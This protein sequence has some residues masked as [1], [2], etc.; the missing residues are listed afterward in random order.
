MSRCIMFIGKGVFNEWA[1]EIA[2]GRTS[3]E[4]FVAGSMSRDEIIS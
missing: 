1:G 2:I 4:S 3:L